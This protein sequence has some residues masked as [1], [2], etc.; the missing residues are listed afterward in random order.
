MTGNESS[1]FCVNLAITLLQ[2]KTGLSK[3][4]FAK[5]FL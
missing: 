1:S 2:L 4:R 3:A 5:I